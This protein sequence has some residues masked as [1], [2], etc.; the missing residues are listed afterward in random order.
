MRRW[1][2]YP[3]NLQRPHARETLAIPRS[4]PRYAQPVRQPEGGVRC[5]NEQ[6]GD[7]RA[8]VNQANPQQVH[9]QNGP[10]DKHAAHAEMEIRHYSRHDKA[11]N[12]E[13]RQSEQTDR[14]KRP[15]IKP[16]CQSHPCNSQKTETASNVCHEGQRPVVHRDESGNDRSSGTSD[17]AAN[18][19][20]H[21]AYGKEDV[22]IAGRSKPVDLPR[23]QPSQIHAVDQRTR[24]RTCGARRKARARRNGQLPNPDHD[25]TSRK[26]SSRVSSST[27]VAADKSCAAQLRTHT[28]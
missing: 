22:D 1:F 15:W 2:P 11:A 9:R 6:R 14:K 27:R 20:A 10:N 16:T 4:I 3:P 25:V 17:A 13:Q 28:R 5:G 26:N 12:Q 8:K 21:R 23:R 18:P 24:Y 19:P 7:P